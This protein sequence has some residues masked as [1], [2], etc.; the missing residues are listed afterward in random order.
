MDKE[1]TQEF[2]NK[3][4]EDKKKDLLMVRMDLTFHLQQKKSIGNE[5]KL[6]KNLKKQKEKIGPKRNLEIITTLETDINVLDNVNKKIN[7]LNAI[8]PQILEYLEFLEKNKV[9]FIKQGIDL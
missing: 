4:I 6:R 5:D 7:E 9:K 3:L 8:E 2:L 1:T